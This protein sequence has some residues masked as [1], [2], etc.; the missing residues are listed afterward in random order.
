M[1]CDKDD[2]DIE[3]IDVF[4]IVLPKISSFQYLDGS[5]FRIRDSKKLEK[6]VLST[7]FRHSRFQSFIRQLNFYSFHV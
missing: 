1:K 6:E 7:F 2:V 5:A 4:E 3:I